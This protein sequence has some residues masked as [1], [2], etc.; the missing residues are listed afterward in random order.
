MKWTAGWNCSCKASCSS[1]EIKPNGRTMQ[2]GP[3]SPFPHT[4]V[5]IVMECRLPSTQSARASL[6]SGEVRLQNHMYICRY[7]KIDKHIV[8]ILILYILIHTHIY[9]YVKLCHLSGP[10]GVYIYRF[11]NQKPPLEVATPSF[12]SSASC[13]P[14][15]VSCLKPFQLLLDCMPFP[16]QIQFIPLAPD[17]ERTAPCCFPHLVEIEAHVKPHV[18]LHPPGTID[19][20]NILSLSH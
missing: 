19:E 16:M 17:L 1:A 12:H 10:F 15:P 3:A 5:T 18:S 8:Y 4:D 20:H 6:P 7:V 11:P 14:L 9:I 13:L 2:S